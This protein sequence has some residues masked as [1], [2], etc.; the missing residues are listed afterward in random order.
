MPD[1]RIS[2]PSKVARG[3]PFEVR[4]QIRH[5]METGYRTDD[6]GKSISRNVIRTLTCKYNGEVVLS[7]HY[8]EGLTASPGRVRVEK[9]EDEHPIPLIR[10]RVDAP[11]ARVTITWQK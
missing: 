1:A 3:E 5:P 8:Q 9:C 6:K 7:L 11:V 2:I 4:L 10:L